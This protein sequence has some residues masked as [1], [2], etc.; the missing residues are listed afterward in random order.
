MAV[1]LVLDD[2]EGGMRTTGGHNLWDA[3]TGEG[4]I[5]TTSVQAAALHSGTRG[6]QESLTAGTD[7]MHFFC[8][9]GSEWAFA[10]ELATSG[11]PWVRNTYNRLG[12]WIRHPASQGDNTGN[13]HLIEFGTYVRSESGDRTSQNAGG[14]HYY[15]YLNPKPDVWTY[16][17]IDPHPQHAVGAGTSD[18]G[19]SNYPTG[20]STWNYM[21]A[22]TRFYWNAPY[23]GLSS[24]PGLFFWDDFRFI[25][26]NN[27]GEDIAH[28]MTLEA[29]Y[30]PATK[31]LHVGFCRST[32]A[33]GDTTYSARYAFSDIWQLGFANAT[34][35]GSVG[36]DG[37]GDY[38]NK[39]INFV[40]DLTGQSVVY[41]AVQMQ[42][43]VGFRQ[44]PLV[45][46][47]APPTQLLPP[48]N[49]RI[50]P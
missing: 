25:Q 30:N 3:Y 5:G 10:H 47:S 40:V 12:F 18:P 34:V 24:Y 9:N 33:G 43:Q 23:T 22:L 1:D 8:N 7:Y 41:I 50:V 4:G 16:V 28:V 44:I 17:L 37:N 26:D 49:F 36:A 13:D 2:F 38:V 21:D 39:Q 32:V 14:T 6:L 35:M 45:L 46:S 31:L 15:H 48:T 42:G 11:G 19:L 20:G 29:S 27:A